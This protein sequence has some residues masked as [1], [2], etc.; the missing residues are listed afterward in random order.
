MTRITLAIGASAVLAVAASATAQTS[1]RTGP[2]S[3]ATPYV[4]PVTGSPVRDLVSILTVGD[5]IGGYTMLGIPDG[6]GA[7]TNN[8]GSFTL[9][10]VHEFGATVASGQRAHQPAG[11]TGG[12][13]V[14]WSWTAT[15]SGPVALSTSGS[16]FDTLLAVYTGTSVDALAAIASNDNAS[17]FATSSRLTFNAVAGRNYRIAVD[18]KAGAAGVVKLSLAIP[19]PNDAFAARA[20]LAA[21][22]GLKYFECSALTGEGLAAPFEWLAGEIGHGLL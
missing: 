19:P 16:S 12:A 7:F 3:S 14:W 8:D 6:M 13:S 11:F 20:S 10:M 4:R 2:N 9:T 22:L 17:T 15:A 1:V 18:G 21:Q 5:S